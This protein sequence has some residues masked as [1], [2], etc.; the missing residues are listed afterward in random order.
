MSTHPPIAAAFPSIEAF[1]APFCV[2][3]RPEAQLRKGCSVLKN[4]WGRSQDTRAFSS[5]EGF[6]LVELLVVV[7]IL[8]VLLAIAVPSYLGFEGACSQ[9]RCEGEPPAGAAVGG[10]V[11]QRQ[12]HLCRD[13]HRDTQVGL[14]LGDRIQPGHRRTAYRDGRYR[15]TDTED[16]HVWSVKGP[17][18][19]ASSYKNNGTCT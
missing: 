16:G 7:A 17:A 11:L 10:G 15:L 19:T 18:I 8:G 12:R 2:L 6:T 14:R 1:A 3:L 5:E 9:Q 4:W 13:E